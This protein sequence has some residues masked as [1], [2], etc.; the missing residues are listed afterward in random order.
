MNIIFYDRYL[1]QYGVVRAIEHVLA[2]D[3]LFNTKETRRNRKFNQKIDE[4]GE[5]AI[6]LLVQHLKDC[7]S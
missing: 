7:F 1:Y 6:N 3:V 2:D 5:K 4:T